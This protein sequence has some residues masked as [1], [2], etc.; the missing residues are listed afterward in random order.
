MVN[1]AESNVFLQF[2]C[3]FYDPTYFSHLISG[4]SAFSE[5]S[6]YTWKFSVHILLKL[7]LKDFEHFKHYLFNM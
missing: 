2:S 4:S 6:L 7:R 5:S 3:L 1:E